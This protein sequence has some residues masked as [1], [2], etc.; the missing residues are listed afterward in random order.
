M[1]L[2]DSFSGV[3][4]LPMLMA[5]PLDDS[6]NL[7]FYREINGLLRDTLD[8]FGV[9][10]FSRSVQWVGAISLTL[11]TLWIMIHGYQIVTG[12]SRDSM[13]TLVTNA[14]KA[15][16]I[17]SVATGMAIGGTTIY[18][19]VTDVLSK[20]ISSIVTGEEGG[21]YENIDRSL[22]FMQV[23]LNSIDAI[24]TGGSEVM[25]KAK[26]RNM[27]FTGVGTAGPA[28]VA[29]TMLLFYKALLSLVVGFGPICVLAL[30]FERTKSI[31]ERW[32]NYAIGT[33]FS[34]S[35]LSFMAALSMDIV[36]AV[37]TS[38]WTGK[39]MGSNPEGINS[40]AL[41]QG[42]LGLILSTLLISVPPA[43]ANFFNGMLGQF[44]P[45]SVFAG[46]APRAPLGQPGRMGQHEYLGYNP[47]YGTNAT[48]DPARY[49]YGLNQS[50]SSGSDAIRKS[51]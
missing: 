38:F 9:N 27:W 39:L 35:V 14:T 43:A 44:T 8:D 10:L 34:L 18:T 16:V 24:Q 2:I 17:I 47:G 45:G 32:L 26:S 30:M 29:G 23:S 22:G 4:G 46:M 15:I 20:Q 19:F 49:T 41:Q 3:G 21:L 40:L 50:A 42:G 51:S 37:S 5:G 11:L 36:A 12:R 48:H 25:E 33:L 7:I 28:I 6:S 1:G 31:F 13:A